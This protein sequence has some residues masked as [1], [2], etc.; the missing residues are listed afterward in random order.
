MK[1]NYYEG[2][3][4]T[5]RKFVSTSCNRNIIG[6]QSQLSTKKFGKRDWS[7]GGEQSRSE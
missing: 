4:V 1:Q 3:A 7:F 5:I 2:Q 6:Q